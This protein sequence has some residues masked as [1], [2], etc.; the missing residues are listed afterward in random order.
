[1]I[2]A[3]ILE[4]H[5]FISHSEFELH[6]EM[7]EPEEVVTTTTKKPTTLKPNAVTEISFEP[8]PGYN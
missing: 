4:I 2:V 6:A 7:A 8:P 1:M 3:Q 5:S